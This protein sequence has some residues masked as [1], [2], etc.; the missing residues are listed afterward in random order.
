M[1]EHPLRFHDQMKSKDIIQKKYKNVTYPKCNSK[2]IKKNAKR[3]TKHRGIIQRYQCKECSYRFVLGEGFY[4][5]RN[6]EKKIT[7]CMDL[8]YNGKSFRYL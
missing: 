4:R 6:H 3:K 7:L 5:M 1:R 2:S 8:Y